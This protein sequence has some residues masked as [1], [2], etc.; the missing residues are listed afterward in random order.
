MWLYNPVERVEHLNEALNDYLVKA[1]EK[2][3]RQNLVT[4]AV[5][6]F[7]ATNRFA[8]TDQYNNSLTIELANATNTTKELREWTKKALHQI[9]LECK[10]IKAAGR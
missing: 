2:M 8:K 7:L 10:E 6:V 9:I 3:R 5:T 4:N 1:G